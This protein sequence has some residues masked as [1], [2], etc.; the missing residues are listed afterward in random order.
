MKPKNTFIYSVAVS[1]VATSDVLTLDP[2]FCRQI[3]CWLR[4]VA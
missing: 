3:S 2:M 1:S 4:S